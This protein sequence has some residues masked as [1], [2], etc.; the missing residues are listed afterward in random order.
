[1]DNEIISSR[2]RDDEQKLHLIPEIYHTETSLIPGL[3]TGL[4][5]FQ[6]HPTIDLIKP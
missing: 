2:K 1:M 6:I 3:T 5:N 4:N